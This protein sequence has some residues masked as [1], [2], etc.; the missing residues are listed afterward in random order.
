MRLIVVKLVTKFLSSTL[1]KLTGILALT[2][3]S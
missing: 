2:T 3:V 1:L